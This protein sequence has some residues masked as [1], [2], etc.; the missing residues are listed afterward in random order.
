MLGIRSAS[1]YCYP[2]PTDL[3]TIHISC[4]RLES[5]RTSLN[6]LRIK[7]MRIQEFKSFKDVANALNIKTGHLRRLIFEE[8][9]NL[10]IEF[11]IPKKDGSFRT[12]YA[13]SDELLFVQ[14]R[15]LSILE[16]SVKTHYKAY[17]F[18]K[19]KNTVDNARIHLKKNYLLNID[20]KDFF[21]SISS[22]RV[23]S[24]FINYFKLYKLS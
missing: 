3:W 1:S 6:N 18:A 4:Q 14:R 15:L 23:R 2:A 20:L 21:P 17:G 13:P 7:K 10:Y 11:E 22:G 5:G 9:N 24:M 12:I 8:R 19:G 16:N